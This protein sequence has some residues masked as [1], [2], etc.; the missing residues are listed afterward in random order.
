MAKSEISFKVQI[1]ANTYDF[2]KKESPQK[3]KEARQK[4][5]EAAGMVWSDEAKRIIR[6]EDHI[7]T[8]LYINSI[9]YR[10]SFPPRHKSGRGVR[11]VTEE[12]I[13]YEL[14]ERE[15]VTRLAIGS[16]V[17]YASELEKRYHIMAKALD[18]GESRMKQVVEFQV[19]KVLGN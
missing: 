7:D 19:R 4:A 18:Q 12:D 17:S 8:G 6:D 2:F 3:L 11:E 10:T 14:E 15:D 9:G 16:N 13:V 5:V 1:D